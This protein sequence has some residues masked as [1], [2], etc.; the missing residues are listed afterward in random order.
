MILINEEGGNMSVL[1]YEI[2]NLEEMD[3]I[4]YKVEVHL[5]D[6]ESVDFKSLWNKVMSE[7]VI[8]ED[9]FYIGYQ[10]YE[11]FTGKSFFYYALAPLRDYCSDEN[12]E[13]IT[14]PKGRYY[15][16][17]SVLHSHGPDFF[18]S[19]YGNLKRKGI[20]HDSTY[21]MEMIPK[22]FTYENP[23]SVLYIAVREKY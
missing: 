4:G 12:R 1:R 9:E 5:N 23:E 18:K 17:N 7:Y 2:I 22:S 3:Y 16:Y 14:I 21:D 19:V 8:D 13:V 6:V 20:I 15:K 10:D 11:S